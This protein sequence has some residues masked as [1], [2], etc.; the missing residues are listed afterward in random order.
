[1]GIDPIAQAGATL[2]EQDETNLLEQS[3][4]TTLLGIVKK[5]PPQLVV[6]RPL[7]Q[8]VIAWANILL[9][10]SALTDGARQRDRELTAGICFTEKNV[11]E[12]MA[13]F[14]AKVPSLE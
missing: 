11:C 13:T 2:V 10:R 6:P 1:M 4:M 5:L 3:K 14:L 7:L 8:L 9:Q 12:R